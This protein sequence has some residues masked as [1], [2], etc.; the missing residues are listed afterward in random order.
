MFSS[1]LV[2]KIIIFRGTSCYEIINGS[3]KIN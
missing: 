3:I 2:E 1:Y